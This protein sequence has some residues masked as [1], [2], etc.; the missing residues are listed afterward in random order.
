M[1]LGL[2]QEGFTIGMQFGDLK[3][4]RR[5]HPNK[6]V[7]NANL[8][9][10]WRCKC[11]CGKLLTVPEYYMRRKPN[12]KTN[13]GCKNQTSRTVH[14]QVYRIWLMMHERCY[15]PKHMAYHNYGGRGIQIAP[16]WNRYNPKFEGNTQEPFEAFLKEIGPR[17]SKQHSVDRIN[18]DLG[19]QPG[20]V[21]WATDLEQAQNR[22]PANNS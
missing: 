18:N 3:L 13:C 2:K 17:P 19:Y 7:K 21:R 10:R 6:R 12:P 16:E 20:N 5:L 14:N 9:V 22:R 11:S 8:K 1:V 15:N 4:L